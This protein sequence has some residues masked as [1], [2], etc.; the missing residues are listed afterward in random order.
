MKIIVYLFTSILCAQIL[1]DLAPG[2]R[3]LG[4]RVWV[5]F[6]D[7][8]QR[9]IIDLDPSSIKRR[10]KHNIDTP[11]TVSYTHLTLPTIYSV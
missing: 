5:Y 3:Q 7:K 10:E 4:Y 9:K 8:D 11:T 6:D 1:T 2:K